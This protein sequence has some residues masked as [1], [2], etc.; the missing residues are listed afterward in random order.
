MASDNDLVPAHDNLIDC[1]GRV[2]RDL[3]ATDCHLPHDRGRSLAG[4]ALKP[5]GKRVFK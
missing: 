4:Q 3:V 2:Q 1:A 5:D